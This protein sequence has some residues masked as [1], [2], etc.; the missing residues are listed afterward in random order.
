MNRDLRQFAPASSLRPSDRVSVPPAPIPPGS[1]PHAFPDNS[2]EQALFRFDLR[3]SLEMHRR[4]AIGFAVAGL[5]LAAAYLFMYWSVYSAQSLVYVQPTPSAVMEGVAPTHWPYNYDPATYDSYVQQQIQSMTRQDV[6]VGALH[7][8]DPGVWQRDGESDESAAER[9]KR[10]I[11]VARVGT[12]YQVSITAHASNAD[13]AAALANAVAASY[14]EDTSHEQMA[15][16]AERLA[17]LKEERDRVKKELDDDR[18]EQA[19]LNAQLGVAAIGPMAPEHYDDDIAKIH[20][21]LVQARTD[22]DK[23]AA[24]LTSVNSGSGLSSAALDAEA[25]QL[26]KEREAEREK[27]A[28]AGQKDATPSAPPVAQTQT[29]QSQ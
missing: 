16:D 15:G 29:P 3:R 4:L 18:A 10:A 17:M 19:A 14:I 23:A 28:G 6:L 25:D 20:D 11:E 22:H 5:I 13:T 7:K 24:Q 27:K 2:A 9:L 26:K 1:V 8:L 12:S 21:A